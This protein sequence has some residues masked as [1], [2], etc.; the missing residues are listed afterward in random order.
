MNEAGVV[1]LFDVDDTLLDHDRVVAGLMRFLER[2]I[3]PERRARYWAF[4]EA[5]RA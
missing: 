2:E 1:I 5:L 3:G 4:F